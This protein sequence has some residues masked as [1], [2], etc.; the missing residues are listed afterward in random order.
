MA[1]T[2]QTQQGS[3]S[4]KQP[5]KQ[6]AAKVRGKAPPPA[7]V[8][9][10][11]RKRPGTV[12]LREIRKYQR[13]TDFLLRKRPFIQVVRSKMDEL[14]PRLPDGR[15]VDRFQLN[16]LLALQEATEAYIIQVLEDANLAAV[17]AKRVTVMPKDIDL[18]KRIRKGVSVRL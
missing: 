2:K 8:V 4:G 13:S 11:K 3:S 14:S 10:P 6:L 5:R 1:R 15:K 7:P 17:H 9:K 16:A 18:S 12:A